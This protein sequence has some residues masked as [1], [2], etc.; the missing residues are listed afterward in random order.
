M[1]GDVASHTEIKYY[2]G[3][4]NKGYFEGVSNAKTLHCLPDST[5]FLKGANLHHNDQERT[6]RNAGSVLQ[7]NQSEV[8]SHGS[9]WPLHHLVKCIAVK[10]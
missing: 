3:E 9:D 6:S 7:S 2:P 10:Q 8:H 1:V 4:A 5:E